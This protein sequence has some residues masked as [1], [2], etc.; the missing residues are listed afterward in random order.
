MKN[1]S[2]SLQQSKQ[3]LLNEWDQEKNGVLTPA[4]VTVFA[5]I[6][7]WWRC[8]VGHSY[9]SR[10]ANRT[11][12]KTGC[13][14]CS[15]RKVLPQDSFAGLFSDLLAE[16][17]TSKNGEL[18]PYEIS[19]GSS[20]KVWWRC[21]NNHSWQA[22]VVSRTTKKTSCDFCRGR[23][24]TKENNATIEDP[25]IAKYWDMGANSKAAG[26]LSKSSSYMAHWICPNGH[27]WTSR[28]IEF[29]KRKK[30]KCLTC[31]SI[32][33]GYPELIKEWDQSRNVGVN[34]LEVMPSSLKKYSWRCERGHTWKSTPAERTRGA[35][36]PRCRSNQTSKP[37]IR[38]F[39][40]LLWL[41]DDDENL[42]KRI[43]WRKK[44]HGKEVDIFVPELNLCIEHDGAFYHASKDDSAKNLILEKAGYKVIR[45]R[46]LPLIKIR[47]HDVLYTA[48]NLKK[49]HLNAILCNL[50]SLLNSDKALKKK[51][52]TYL[53]M[54]NFANESNFERLVTILPSPLL[55][56][57]MSALHS[58]LAAE[59]DT[60]KNG[61]GPE[62]VR[63]FS[64]HNA[65]W[66]CRNGHSWQQN[67]RD[68]VDFGGKCKLC[69]S[70]AFN[71]PAIAAEWNQGLNAP[72]TSFDISKSSGKIVWWI[73]NKGHEWQS[74]VNNRTRSKRS[75]SCP[76]CSTT[77]NQFNNSQLNT[78]LD[79]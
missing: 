79:L 64:S 68:R 28:V 75:T 22:Q 11:K 7:V 31:L 37:E 10:V 54:T 1:R 21:S 9:Q 5:D 26:T 25:E 62:S 45:V 74:A 42:Q 55:A 44:I 40:E 56:D 34:L 46:E 65:W 78:N 13:P 69:N 50:K 76:H 6:K 17:D 67:V 61:I 47:N 19:K 51:L 36:C 33:F 24:A 8:N 4:D 27:T 71:F 2:V 16:F 57:S 41:F 58:N 48:G 39:T 53:E 73:C 12:N 30:S 15:G 49:D 70:L 3:E 63:P 23:I 20:K 66:L 32:G 60:H 18:D 59:W 72:L 29:I 38:I 35:E 43:K 14:F 77:K 52:N